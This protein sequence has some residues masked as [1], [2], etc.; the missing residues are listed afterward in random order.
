[1]GLP[2]IWQIALALFAEAKFRC[3]LIWSL[4]QHGDTLQ[5]DN[6]IELHCILFLTQLI[7]VVLLLVLF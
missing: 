7:T 3:L 1:M 2:E 5:Q 4:S 6:R